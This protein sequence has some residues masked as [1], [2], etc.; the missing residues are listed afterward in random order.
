MDDNAICTR[1]DGLG[2]ERR[3]ITHP[4]ANVAGWTCEGYPFDWW[5]RH[6]E[7]CDGTG[8][9]PRGSSVP[10]IPLEVMGSQSRRFRRVT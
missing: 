9:R 10:L 6:C 5:R 1:C 4:M 3:R 8:Y 2:V 7:A